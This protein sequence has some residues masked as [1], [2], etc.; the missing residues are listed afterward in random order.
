MRKLFTH[1]KGLAGAMNSAPAKLSGKAMRDFPVLENAWLM[2]DGDKFHSF[3]TMDALPP[4]IESRATEVHSLEGQWILPAFVDSHTHI[5]FAKTR[6]AEFEDRIHG[7][8]YE[9]IAARGGGILNSAGVLR[10]TSEEDLLQTALKR[11][12]FMMQHGTGAVEIKS[13]YG[14]SI[15]AEIKMLRVIKEIKKLS[16]IPVKATFLGAHAIPME[17]KTN[18]NEYIRQIIEEMLPQIAEENLADFIDVFCDRGFFTQAETEQILAAGAQFGLL[19]KIH[20]NE[21]DFTGG[22]QAGVKYGALSVDHLECTGEEEIAVLLASDTM[23]TLLPSTAFFLG[24][25]YPPARKMIDSGLPIALASDFNPGSSPSGSMPFVW[26][27]AC[28]KLKMDP[29]EALAAAT[30]NSAYAL[31]LNTELGSITPGKKASFIITQSAEALA[32]F[33][34]AFTDRWIHSV[35]VNGQLQ[36]A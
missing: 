34:Y 16:P 27:L 29:A 15:E 21:L 2:V 5:V 31:A 19:P 10:N 9:E 26:S 30:L 11:L 6:E 33:P 20:A 7:L 13:G 28:I 24:M 36:Q 32:Y 17:Y 4:E 25:E 12:S 3:G 14:L 1:I 22:I 18:R 35:Y 23:P 8:T